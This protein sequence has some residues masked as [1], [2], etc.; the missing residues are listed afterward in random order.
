M[1]ASVKETLEDLVALGRGASGA[2]ASK[3]GA[4]WVA[5]HAN[6]AEVDD[7]HPLP[8]KLGTDPTIDI[9]EVDQGAKADVAT[10][11]WYVQLVDAAGAAVGVATQATLAALSAKL[12]AALG[13]ATPAGSLAVVA[14]KVTPAITA[15]ALAASK[16]IKA[17][18]GIHFSTQV[19]IDATAPSATYYVQMINAAALPSNGAVTHLHAPQTVIHVSGVPDVVV[20]DDTGAP[21]AFTTGCVAALSTT[22]F[23]LT[24]GGAYLLVDGSAS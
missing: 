2:L 9:G 24:I 3:W 22:Q 18:A 1:I 14:A 19:Q 23:T 20:F 16:V 10:D 21:A 12:P 6:G 11:A 4:L 15:S 8:V 5:L 13:P 17:A 7:A